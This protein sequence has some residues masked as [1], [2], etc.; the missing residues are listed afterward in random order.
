MRH[1]GDALVCEGGGGRMERTPSLYPSLSYSSYV[2]ELSLRLFLSLLSL[3]SESRQARKKNGTAW[4]CPSMPFPSY[5]KNNEQY[6]FD[7]EG[8]GGEKQ[9]REKQQEGI[10]N[11]I[12]FDTK[13]MTVAIT[14]GTIGDVA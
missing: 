9:E 12:V 7:G 1:H 10:Q 6:Q 8:G 13:R 3:L 4:G 11:S 2:L 14:K 5:P